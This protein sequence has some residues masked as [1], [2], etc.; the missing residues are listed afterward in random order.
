VATV[1]YVPF[2]F[3]NLLVPLIAIAYAWTGTFILRQEPV[4]KQA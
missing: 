2:A 4:E 1:S 3:L